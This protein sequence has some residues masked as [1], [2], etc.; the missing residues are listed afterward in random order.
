M[1]NNSSQP[2]Q[3]NF[4]WISESFVLFKRDAWI[5]VLSV[6][7]YFVSMFLLNVVLGAALMT[8]RYR[9]TGQLTAPAQP[10]LQTLFQIGVPYYWKH[11]LIVNLL[12]LPVMT[13]L[14]EG[15][16]RMANKAAS[17]SR[18]KF[19]D[20]FSGEANFRNFLFFNVCVWVSASFGILIATIYG[21]VFSTLMLPLGALLASTGEF[22]SSVKTSFY[23]MREDW[24]SAAAFSLVLLCLGTVSILACCIPNLIVYSMA[25]ILSP[26]ACRDMVVVQIP[27][28]DAYCSRPGSWPP[29]PN[30]NAGLSRDNNGVLPPKAE[31]AELEPAVDSDG[32]TDLS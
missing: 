23:A 3:V 31:S 10:T 24:L 29:P 7:I 8:L 1:I 14:G 22:V 17:G 11:T 2:R 21:L 18:L 26:L 32:P 15:Q 30:M 28:D 12:S 13:Y 27:K 4:G 5:W 9:L 6:V 19:R 25:L 20:I 16:C